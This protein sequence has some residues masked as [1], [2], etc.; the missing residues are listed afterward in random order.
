MWTGTKSSLQLHEWKT[1]R[2]VFS[3][4]GAYDEIVGLKAFDGDGKL[5]SQPPYYSAVFGEP[6]LIVEI[7]ELPVRLEVETAAESQEL[8]VPFDLAMPEG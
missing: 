7:S 8:V 4:Q 6:Q 1:G 3:V 5:I 2:L